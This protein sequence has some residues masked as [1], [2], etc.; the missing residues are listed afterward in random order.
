MHTIYLI[1]TPHK[2]YI[3]FTYKVHEKRVEG[4][5][6]WTTFIHSVYNAHAKHQ[7]KVKNMI[8]SIPSMMTINTYLNIL[9]SCRMVCEH[10]HVFFSHSRTKMLQSL[11]FIAYEIMPPSQKMRRRK[12]MLVTG[13]YFLL[14][15]LIFFI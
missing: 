2:I 13:E 15:L 7:N 10:D 14:L 12:S 9:L 6:F 5:F 4:G 8:H 1:K 3:Y 11:G